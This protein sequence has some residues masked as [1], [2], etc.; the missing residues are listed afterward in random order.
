MSFLNL[1]EEYIQILSDLVA[2]NTISSV[3]E[4][5]QQSNRAII[6]YIEDF[7][8]KLGFYTRIYTIDDKRYNLFVASSL[9]KGG[10][11]LT[12]HTD[13]VSYRADK[14]HSDPFKLKVEN[15]KAYGLG[16]TDMKGSVALIMLLSKYCYNSDFKKPLTA[17]FTCDEESSMSGARH[18]LDNYE[19][20]P[21][22]IVVTEPSGNRPCIGHKGCTG[23]RLTI[24]GKACHSSTPD[25]GLDAIDF[26]APF[27]EE[28]NKLKESIKAFADKRFPV[29]RPT[30]SFG[31][32]HG[33]ESF[34]IICPKVTMLFDVRALPSY[35]CSQAYDDLCDI[36]DKLNSRYNNV[37]SLEKT[38]DNIDAFILDDKH[39]ISM[40]E[41]ITD[42]ESFCTNGCAEAG[43][44][45]KIA[46]T[47]I[48][49][50]SSS[51]SAHQDNE[52]IP[53]DDVEHG[54]DIFKTLISRICA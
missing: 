18:Y 19:H 20:Q 42:K 12:G 22:F 7:Y 21:D 23:Y 6:E 16:V 43:F 30:I 32:V 35:S 52:D 5:L 36:V 50:P 46:P 45:S 3:D 33:G 28:V 34:N 49:G 41:E 25:K 47:A 13:T 40:L 4:R 31:A 8:K 39:L 44:L 29:E 15:N 14:W 10:L 24:T 48:L 38:F 27:I 54:F 11:L 26:I 9:T 1:K 2:F 53:L 51:P 17:L 37:Y